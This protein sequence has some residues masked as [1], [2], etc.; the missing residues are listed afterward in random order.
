L[1]DRIETLTPDDGWLTPSSKSESDAMDSDVDGSDGESEGEGEDPNDGEDVDEGPATIR[2]IN[3]EAHPALAIDKLGREVDQHHTKATFAV[4]HEYDIFMEHAMS[5]VSDPPDDSFRARF[6]V[7]G[8]PGIG[9]WSSFSLL[10]VSRSYIA[11]DRQEL[12]LLLFPF[13]SARFGTAGILRQ[14]LRHC[15]LLFQ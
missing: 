10:S 2:Y 12:R 15:V 3:L 9:K 5:R 1:R 7:T 4:R 14:L 8:Q 6:F 13:S 11:S